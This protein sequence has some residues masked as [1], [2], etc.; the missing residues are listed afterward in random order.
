LRPTISLTDVFGRVL[1]V[2]A[3]TALAACWPAWQAGRREPSAA[4]RHV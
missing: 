1:L 3:I 2:V 4:L